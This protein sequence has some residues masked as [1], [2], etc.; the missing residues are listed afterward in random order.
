MWWS[1]WEKAMYSAWGA[2]NLSGTHRKQDGPKKRSAGGLGEVFLQLKP[3]GSAAE[4]G[5]PRTTLLPAPS[6]AGSLG[7]RRMDKS[8]RPQKPR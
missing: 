3:E 5:P 4:C 1:N 6:E 8:R 7:M 2:G